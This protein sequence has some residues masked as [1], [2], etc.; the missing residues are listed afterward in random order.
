MDG[1]QEVDD[2]HSLVKTIG[3]KTYTTNVVMYN[4]IFDRKESGVL[5]LLIKLISLL[6][7]ACA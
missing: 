4:G 3:I 6:S 5:C 7:P 2:S 1:L